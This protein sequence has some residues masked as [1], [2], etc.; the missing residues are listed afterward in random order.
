MFL[1]ELFHI[2]YSV[3]LY[4]M[5][6]YYIVLYYIVL[7][8]LPDYIALYHSIR[9]LLYYILLLLLDYIALNCIIRYQ[10]LSC[11]VTLSGSLCCIILNYTSLHTMLRCN[12]YIYICI[13]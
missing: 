6:L 13:V 4:S 12:I 10:I 3:V 2:M 9:I 11:Y 7:Y 5:L 8:I 1:G